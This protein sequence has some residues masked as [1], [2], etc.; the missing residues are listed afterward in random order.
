MKYEQVIDSLSYFICSS[1]DCEFQAY[2]TLT[3]EHPLLYV[4]NLLREERKKL[5]GY[6]F[7]DECKIWYKSDHPGEACSRC[8]APQCCPSCC[9]IQFCKDVY[10]RAVKSESQRAERA[11]VSLGVWRKKCGELSAQV[12]RLKGEG[13]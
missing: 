6:D 13:A 3:G 5:D 2:I 4:I 1:D 9:K 10:D 11:E 7:C 8:G 12:E